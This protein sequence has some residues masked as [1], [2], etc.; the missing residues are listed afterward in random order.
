MMNFQHDHSNRPTSQTQD[1]ESVFGLAYEAATRYVDDIDRRDVMPTFEAMENLKSIHE[2]LPSKSNDPREVIEML[3]QV[4][5]PATVVTTGGRFFGFVVGGAM[6][7]TIAANWLASTW[8]QNAGTWVLAPFA[9]EVEDVV[10]NWMLEILDLP[11]DAAVGFVTG[12]TMGTFSALAAAR[13][14]LLRK[15]GF[16][17]KRQGIRNAPEIR[18]VMS[19]EIH[20]TNIATLGY[21]GFGTD[22]IET[23][24]TDEQGRLRVDEMPD[25]DSRTIVIL[26]AGNINSGSFD[27]FEEICNRAKR[28]GAW[29]H[30]D[31]AFG[32]WARAS[33]SKR[34]LTKGVELAD[35]WSVDGHKWLNIPQDS[36]IYACRD[37]QAVNDVF[38]TS[39]TYLMRDEHRQPNNLVP[40]LSRRARGI[41]FWAALKTLGRQGV[42]ELVDRNCQHATRFAEG[43]AA[44]GYDVLNDVVLN[45][46]VFACHDEATTRSALKQIQS[47]G[48]TWLGPTTW[49]GRFSMR[50]SISSWRT[51]EEDVQRSLAVMADALQQANVFN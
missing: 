29:V 31:G 6:P 1:A 20:P 36:A 14:A 42:E 47:S 27:A 44:A 41:E 49:K 50:I 30:V 39:A 28:V 34:H 26:Q 18:I 17:L 35:S 33:A 32:L 13:S 38:G 45:Q 5:A 24:P 11:R 3:E 12:S 25:L 16:D 37:H 51:T 2:P 10:A 21:L 40:E 46:V 48:V 7:V 22:E 23:C 19:E 8:D 4:G 43:L 15:A 9:T